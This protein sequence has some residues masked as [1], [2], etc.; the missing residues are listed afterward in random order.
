MAGSR[1]AIYRS[2]N[3]EGGR[4]EAEAPALL[5]PAAWLVMTNFGPDKWSAPILLERRIIGRSRAA[6]IRIPPRLRFVS[7]QHAAVWSDDER[8]L[9]LED[10][11]STAGTSVNGLLLAPHRPTQLL[12]G[13]RLR[14]GT[15]EL[16]VKAKLV[17]VARLIA[18]TELSVSDL[19]PSVSRS[20]GSR[21]QQ[22][23]QLILEL[24]PAQSEIVLWMYR[25]VFSNEELADRLGR[26]VNTIRTQ[27]GHIFAKLGVNSRAQLMS[28]F[29]PPTAAS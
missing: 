13:D 28:L 26:S 9:W 2:S 4:P 8:K 14:L 29:R 25:G 16:K 17:G 19:D 10:L 15:L 18:E 7:R 12:A 5:E 6:Q 11:H 1:F 21:I 24:T 20:L 23:R 27:I 22:Q 3:P